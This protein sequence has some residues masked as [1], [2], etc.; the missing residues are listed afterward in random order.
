MSTERQLWTDLEDSLLLRAVQQCKLSGMPRQPLYAY[1]T[2]AGQLQLSHVD[3]RIVS[4]HVPGRDRKTCRKRWY[5]TVG[6]SVRNGHWQSDEDTRL[7]NAVQ[8]CGEGWTRVSELVQTRSGDQCM[9]RWRDYVNP[10]LNHG[11]WSPEEDE[12]LKQAVAH[13]GRSWAQI[14]AEYLPERSALAIRHRFQVLENRS[15]PVN[16]RLNAGPF[17]FE[18]EI[19]GS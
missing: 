4:N 13:L 9:K 14:T 2:C 10:R 1:V 19:A 15:S 18:N 17:L 12:K 3:W 7:L 5:Q 16:Q 11:P 6:S 8:S